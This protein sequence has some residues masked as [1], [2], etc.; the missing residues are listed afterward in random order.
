MSN[1]PQL[2]QGHL[3]LVGQQ[4]VPMAFEYLEG[5]RIHHLSGQPVSAIALVGV[6]CTHYYVGGKHETE[7]LR[8]QEKK[9][10]FGLQ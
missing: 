4:P 1:P 8:V 3:E 9:N 7:M 5:M 10:R 2:K 6:T